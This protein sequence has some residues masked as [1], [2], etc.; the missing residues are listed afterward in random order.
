MHQPLVVA[1]LP[2]HKSLGTARW[3][4]CWS[5]AS[6]ASWLSE[7]PGAT[8]PLCDGEDQDGSWEDQDGSWEDPESSIRF[9]NL[10]WMCRKYPL[11]H[12]PL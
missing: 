4:G 12:L 5:Q 1:C 10:L 7:H 3:P 6:A 8:S 2:H 11:L 9:G